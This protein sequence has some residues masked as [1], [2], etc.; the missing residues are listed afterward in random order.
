M[1]VT[2]FKKENK[3]VNAEIIDGGYEISYAGSHTNTVSY[4]P[5]TGEIENGKFYYEVE[6]LDRG[7][8]AHYFASFLP[9]SYSHG[10]HGFW[11]NKGFGLYAQSDVH[12]FR[13]GSLIKKLGSDAEIAS[14]TI[15][16][17]AIDYDQK[18]IVFSKNGEYWT[19]IKYHEDYFYIGYGGGL[20]SQGSARFNFGNEPFHFDVP[21]GYLPYDFPRRYLLKFGDKYYAYD[22][23]LL[24]VGITDPCNDV[25]SKGMSNLDFM[26]KKRRL[27]DLKFVE[28]V[29]KVNLSRRKRMNILGVT[30]TEREIPEKTHFTLNQRNVKTED[31]L[32]LDFVGNVGTTESLVEEIRDEGKYYYEITNAESKTEKYA[33]YLGGLLDSRYTTGFRGNGVISFVNT[34]GVLKITV[35]TT[36]RELLDR[37]LNKK[38]VL[39]IAIDFDERIQYFY[40]NG[41]KVE[42]QAFLPNRKYRIAS[43]GGNN[44]GG[45]ATYNF[46]AKPFVYNVPDGFERYDELL[47]SYRVQVDKEYLDISESVITLTPEPV[48]I[49]GELNFDKEYATVDGVNKTITNFLNDKGI[50]NVMLLSDEG[51]SYIKVEQDDD[52]FDYDNTVFTDFEIV[53]VTNSKQPPNLNISHVP[54]KSLLLANGDF[55][56][57]TVDNI[58]FFKIDF[59]R[60]GDADIKLITS[61]D[62]GETWKSYDGSSWIDIEPN[63]DEVGLYGIPVEQFNNIPSEKWNDLRKYS[64]KIRFG[65]YLK[66]NEPLDVAKIHALNAQFDMTG[67]WFSANKGTDYKYSYP[68]NSTIKVTI[69]KNGDYKINY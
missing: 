46:G 34:E 54:S 28:G 15:I 3:G 39:G 64:N 6:I 26:K 18:K 52:F 62:E 35:N 7:T 22:G 51:E 57:K 48:D 13:N 33:F 9:K 17:I 43:G 55:A 49:F 44:S 69:L 61:V 1:S 21:E 47:P 4:I 66:H 53:M 42:E 37:P 14:G 56:L 38:D 20:G 29:K 50:E 30:N 27:Y 32:T 40:L 25:M 65:Y 68:D 2:K 11:N 36:V 8:A 45:V 5:E 41:E 12:V 60:V 23:D 19:D 16:G 67:E 24:E 10:N 31:G 63:V 58:D 59:S